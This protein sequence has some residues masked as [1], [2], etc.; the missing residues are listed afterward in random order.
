MNSYYNEIDPFAAAWLREL[1][2]DGQIAAGHVDERSITD[3]QP[4]D[5]AGFTQC[6]FFAGIGGWAYALRLADWPD[7][8]PVWT[9]SCPCQ[10]FSAAGTRTGG[11]DDRHLWPHWAR[12]IRECRPVT[13]FGEQ[14]ESAIAHGWLDAVFDDLER[15]GYACG[16]ACVPAAGVGA[17]HIRQRVWFVADSEE[18]RA[19]D[20]EC[21]ERR[22]GDEAQA[23]NRDEQPR[24]CGV[25]G[26]VADAE[27]AE[28]RP[29]RVNDERDGQ[30]AGRAQ[31]HGEPRACREVRTLAHADGN[32]TARH[33]GE[34]T[35]ARQSC[36][37]EPDGGGELGDT[38]SGRRPRQRD[39]PAHALTGQTNPWASAEWIACR[40]GKSR[41]VEPGIFPLAHGVSKR[42]GLLRGA[43]NAIVPA[44]AAEVIRAYMAVAA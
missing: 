25:S 34:E 12:L 5:L 32:R 33:A 7:D 6:H 10:P 3:V 39:Q 9:G 40:D 22:S 4:D 16:A 35:S 15:E 28:R 29:Q 21:R 13:V 17:P 1:I 19:R 27:H 20:W 14:V 44:V 31:A 26:L 18:Q 23:R 37:P 36:G 43:G 8:R 38:T 41:P 24:D 30:D 2:K 42:V 11:R